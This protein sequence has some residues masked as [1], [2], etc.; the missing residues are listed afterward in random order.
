MEGQ[1]VLH[2][3]PPTLRVTLAPT[4]EGGASVTV[5]RALHVSTERDVG[6]GSFPS[7]VI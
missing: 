4:N 2:T 7:T 5:H 3:R 1:F 6:M